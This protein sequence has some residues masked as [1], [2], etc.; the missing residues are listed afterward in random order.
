MNDPTYE[1]GTPPRDCLLPGDRERF[2]LAGTLPEDWEG[3]AVGEYN[4]APGAEPF[5]DD[6]RGEPAS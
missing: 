2:N 6:D 1:P 3:I 5:W 4:Y